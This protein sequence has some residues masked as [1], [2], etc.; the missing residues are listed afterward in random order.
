MKKLLIYFSLLIA[1]TFLAKSDV[2]VESFNDSSIPI[3]HIRTEDSAEILSRE[4][5]IRCTVDVY[6]CSSNYAFDNATAN[7]KVRGNTTAHHGDPEQIREKGAPYRL[8]F[9]RKINILGL[10][11][12]AL[13]RSWV[14]LQTSSGVIS[15]DSFVF[16]MG[17]N[18]LGDGQFCSDSRY[19][20]LFINNTFR[21]LYLLCE[22]S[23]VQENRVNIHEPQAG[24]TSVHTGYFLEIDNYATKEPDNVYFPMH[25]A[26]ATITD[27]NGVTRTFRPTFYSIKSSVTVPEQVDFIA[28]RINGI[29]TAL[30]EACVNGRYMILDEQNHLHDSPFTSAYEVADALV[31]L[32]SVVNMYILYEII[33]DYDIGDGSFYMSV[34][35]SPGSANRKLQFTCPW[36]FTWGFGDAPAGQYYAG[37]FC[38]Q[39][40]MDVAGDRSNPWFVLLM[41]Q[42]WFLSLVKE[43]WTQL[44]ID[45]GLQESLD[46][47]MAFLQT[48]IETLNAISEVGIHVAEYLYNWLNERIQWL[49]SEWLI[50][51]AA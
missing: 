26:G 36:D 21:G 3:L 19:V 49:D 10:N 22:Q 48:H 38:T 23:Q 17:Q 30:Y 5:Y 8:Q 7:V 14:L 40:F 6:N 2:R 15:P 12:E 47:E 42:D 32:D 31:D 9:D 33:H 43:R 18:I 1:L 29:F 27:I 20:Q 45:G 44:R 4:E 46:A 41:T 51:P 16:H 35:L 11:D 28:D 34:D 13:C 39:E 24:E 50:N 25:Y 37:T